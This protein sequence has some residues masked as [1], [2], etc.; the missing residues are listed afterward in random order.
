MVINLINFSSESIMG[1]EGIG[2]MRMKLGANTYTQ[3][4]PNGAV[5]IIYTPNPAADYS[6]AWDTY[7]MKIPGI[8]RLDTPPSITYTLPAGSVDTL[9]IKTYEIKIESI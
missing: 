1:R 2:T 3:K 8:G 5:K 4:T 9:V 7:I 6:V